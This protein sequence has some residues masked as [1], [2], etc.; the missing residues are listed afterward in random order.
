MPVKTTVNLDEELLRRARRSAADRGITF[1]EVLEE[2]LRAS[3]MAPARQAPFT[4]RWTPVT[5]TGP[6]LVDVDDRDALYD[7]LEGRS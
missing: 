2:A 5:G 3:V 6:P 7:L 1:R 4:F